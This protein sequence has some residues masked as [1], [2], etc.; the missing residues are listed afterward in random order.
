MQNRKLLLI[1]DDVIV[2]ENYKEL[3]TMHGYDVAVANDGEEG[4]EEIKN[5]IPDLIICDIRMPKMDGYQVLEALQKDAKIFTGFIFLSA[6]VEHDDI[7]KG[8]NSGADDY[9]TKPV[10]STDLLNAI[11]S[12]LTVRDKL[13]AEV[14]RLIEATMN[15]KLDF[16][17]V[18][19]RKI[20]GLLTKSEIHILHHVAQQR[21]TQEI[22]DLVFLSPKT[23]ENH[24]HNICKKLGLT[25]G[26]S[27]LTLALKIK[28]FLEL[29]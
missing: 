3:L 9:L 15:S 28:P 2:R 19:A 6:R 1:E 11:S 29:N 20:L 24:R 12:R 16:S 17:G 27:V 13:I 5:E 22:A 18:D 10:S 26:H 23:V 14:N 7:R 25:G 8:M 4:L 21:T